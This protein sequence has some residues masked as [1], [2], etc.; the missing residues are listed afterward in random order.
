MRIDAVEVKLNVDPEQVSVALERLG[1]AGVGSGRDIFFAEDPQS[2]GGALPLLDG[3]VVLRVRRAP[4]K[5]VDSTVKLRPCRRSQLTDEWLQLPKGKDSDTKLE[6]DWVGERKVLAASMSADHGVASLVDVLEHRATVRELFSSAQ[7]DFLGV[8]SDIRVNLNGLTLLGPIAAS[9]WEHIDLD[10]IDVTAERW[11][12]GELD[13][14]ELSVRTSLPE[15]P[16][17]QRALEAGAHARQ[18]SL[19]DRQTTKTRLVL[20]YLAASAIGLND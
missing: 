19:D 9:R 7:R 16:G 18:L 2:D 10:G 1:L 12:I 17:A 5:K 11:R 20:E 6:G 14:L 13:F 8:C 15:A 3:G 4:D